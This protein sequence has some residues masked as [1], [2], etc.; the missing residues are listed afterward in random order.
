M[1]VIIKSCVVGLT[2]IYALSQS[3]AQQRSNITSNLI[4]DQNN[5]AEERI[6]EGSKVNLP[7]EN[8]V[9][10]LLYRVLNQEVYF[11]ISHK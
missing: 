7:D 10:I 9:L 1:G 3:D 6:G 5:S 2:E 4:V 11:T 8:P